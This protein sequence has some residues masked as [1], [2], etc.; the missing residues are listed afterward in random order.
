ML[1][2]VLEDKG[3]LA[4]VELTLLLRAEFRASWVGNAAVRAAS[5]SVFVALFRKLDQ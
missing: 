3:R 5:M 4:T 1:S 2:K